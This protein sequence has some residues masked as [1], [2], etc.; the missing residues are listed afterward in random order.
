MRVGEAIDSVRE[1]GWAT[2]VFA[3]M[4]TPGE[5]RQAADEGVDIVAPAA[6]ETIDGLDRYF[7]D[8]DQAGSEAADDDDDDDEDEDD[9]EDDDE[10]TGGPDHFAVK[11]HSAAEGEATADEVQSAEA[12]G[13]EEKGEEKTQKKKRKRKRKLRK[14]IN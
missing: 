4:L 8:P 7:I 5:L 9:E 6:G 2:V 1:A 11:P 12:S 10:E 14:G 13:E 3:A